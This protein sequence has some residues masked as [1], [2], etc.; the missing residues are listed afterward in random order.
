MRL[1]SKK[2]LVLTLIIILILGV[3]VYFLPD[4]GYMIFFKN[5]SISLVGVEGKGVQGDFVSMSAFINVTNNAGI[6]AV[7]YTHLT[8]PTNREV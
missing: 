2:V 3:L 6:S 7:S 4:I 8:L 5:P 1:L